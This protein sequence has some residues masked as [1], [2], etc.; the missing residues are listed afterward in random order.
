[1]QV[2][3][4][5]FVGHIVFSAMVLWPFA[6]KPSLRSKKPLVQIVCAH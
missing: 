3:W 4:L 1:M 5:R 6:F 2:T